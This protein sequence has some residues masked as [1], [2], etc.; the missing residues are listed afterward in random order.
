MPAPLPIPAMTNVDAAF[1]QVLNQRLAALGASIAAAGA[2]PWSA[3][4]AT[5]N[6]TAG[7]TTAAGAIAFGPDGSFYVCYAANRWLRIGP[8]GYSNTF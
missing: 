8:G 7:T 6:G 1:L 4:P 3:V 2:I 5:S